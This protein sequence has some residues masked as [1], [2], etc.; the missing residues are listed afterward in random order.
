MSYSDFTLQAV[1]KAFQLVLNERTALF[2]QV[3][4]LALSEH[5]SMTLKDNVPLALAINTEK[6]RSELIIAVVLV[7]LR[8]RLNYQISLFSGPA[9]LSS[10]LS[11]HRPLLL[12]KRKMKISK[13][14]SGS[15]SP[16][17]WLHASFMPRKV[18]T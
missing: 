12:L 15:V 2:A 9:P 6:A 3:P 11:V 7:E 10:C 8:K 16:Q 1:V 5:F 4:E 18:K 14:E 17:C 13:E